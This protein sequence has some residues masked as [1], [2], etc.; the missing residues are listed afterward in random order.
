MNFQ[1]I[2]ASVM[3]PVLIV[4]YARYELLEE[5]LQICLNAGVKDIYVSQD[6]LKAGDLKAEASHSKVKSLL[7]GF[8]ESYPE[9]F[10]LLFRPSNI[11]CAANVV[12]SCDWIFRDKQVAIVLEDDCI[13]SSDF[14]QYCVQA[15]PVLNDNLD[16]WL[17]CGSQPFPNQLGESWVM[18][19]YPLIWG[20]C[21]TNTKWRE[22]R[23]SIAS[24]RI[25]KSVRSN[26]SQPEK[27]FWKA[28]ARR[29]IH[30]FT[31]VW[32]TSLV[33]QMN[34][35]G[36]YSLLPSDNLVTNLGHDELAT[37][38]GK[39]TPGL[40][41]NTGSFKTP[42]S[43]PR[44]SNELDSLIRDKYY[45]IRWRHYVTTKWTFLRDLTRQ[46]TFENSFQERIDSANQHWF[47]AK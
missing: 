26:L 32:D 37:H 42:G 16:L 12:S 21:T 5:I 41:I 9:N 2:S 27:S 38:T 11:G 30:G 29:A 46:K 36:K 18:S 33:Y 43:S 45:K 14:L 23:Q 17:A 7:L 8:K 6:G 44:Y 25:E 3:P 15:I 24:L 4:S 22:I 10:H 35:R 47:I 34:M 40:G 39:D 31:D 20:W 19:K 13:P 1:D 28:G